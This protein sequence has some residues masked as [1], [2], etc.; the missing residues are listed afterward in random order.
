MPFN[1][2][3]KYFLFSDTQLYHVII[4]L[5][6]FLKSKRLK[7][8]VLTLRLFL[9]TCLACFI[10]NLLKN[11]IYLSSQSEKILRLK[12][13]FFFFGHKIIPNSTIVR[14][15]KNPSKTINQ[16]QLDCLPVTSR[17]TDPGLT[18]MY[19]IR[20]IMVIKEKSLK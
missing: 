16:L 11:G 6:C 8:D 14:K 13:L 2:F 12:T 4:L 19:L 3:S 1:Y 18:C 7:L 15:G 10:L 9:L 17:R 5:G 20:R